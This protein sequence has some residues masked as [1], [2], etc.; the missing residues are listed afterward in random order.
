M[1]TYD[2]EVWLSSCC[3]NS[4]HWDSCG[5][6]SLFTNAALHHH[7][8]VLEPL[9]LAVMGVGGGVAGEVGL[10]TQDSSGKAELKHGLL[11]KKS[12]TSGNKYR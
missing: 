7:H 6:M 5:L 1:S 9:R 11:K 4:L 2:L 12:E 10:R 8:S 3:E